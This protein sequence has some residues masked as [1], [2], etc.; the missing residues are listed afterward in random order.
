MVSFRQQ[1][2]G[3]NALNYYFTIILTKNLGL[4][5]LLARILTGCNATS[6]MI[7]S[8]CAFWII[9]RF[10]RRPLMLTGLS[11]QSFAYVMVAIAIGLLATAP[12][13]VSA[14]DAQ[15]GNNLH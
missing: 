5:T 14:R 9:D 3:I 10:G 2:G 6:Y 8:A 12:Y 4:N 1:F 11:L 13:E 7:S 15:Y